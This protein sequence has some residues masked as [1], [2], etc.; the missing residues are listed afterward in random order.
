MPGRLIFH[1]YLLG[2]HEV[3]WPV[4]VSDFIKFAV[5]RNNTKNHSSIDRADVLRLFEKAESFTEQK[6]TSNALNPTHRGRGRC[7]V[8][9]L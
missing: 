2:M 5:E 8:G 9:G 1:K 4:S 6:E 3:K 7:A